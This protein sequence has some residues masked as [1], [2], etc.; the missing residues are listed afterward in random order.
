MEAQLHALSN[1]HWKE[2]ES[3]ASRPGHFTSRE[4]AT[5]THW[6]GGCMD[7]GAGLDMKAK[8]KIIA[9]ARN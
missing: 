9:S 3:L 2:V 1:S 6:R 4:R 5:G 8:K 7:P